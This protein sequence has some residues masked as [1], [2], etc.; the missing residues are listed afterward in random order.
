MKTEYRVPIND[1]AWPYTKYVGITGNKV[2][3]YTFHG[4]VDPWPEDMNVPRFVKPLKE[5]SKRVSLKE[6][7]KRI[8][9]LY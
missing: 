1:K 5:H 7:Q 4:K 9:P 6:A 2:V 8:P 3:C